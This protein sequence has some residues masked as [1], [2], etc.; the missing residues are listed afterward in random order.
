MVITALGGLG[1][2]TVILLPNRAI[3]TKPNFWP[4]AFWIVT[5]I[6][7]IPFVMTKILF[8]NNDIEPILVF[9]RDNQVDDMLTIGI[10]GFTKS[11]KTWALLILAIVASSFILTNYKKHFEK[12][13]VTFSIGMLAISPLTQYIRTTFLPTAEH[14]DFVIEDRMYAPE[15]LQK[16]SKQKNVV[17]VYLES[18][19]RSYG[20][21]AEFKPYFSPIQ[22]IADKSLELTNFVQTTGTGYTIAGVVSTQCGIPLLPNGLETVF[23]RNG[24]EASMKGFLPSVH[25][26]GDQLSKD[27]YTLYYMNGASLD[28]FSKRS[29][30]REHGYSRPFDI[31][32]LPDAEK[33]GRTNVW[34]LNDGLLFEN[35]TKEFDTLAASN[36][37][38]VQSI[39]SISTHGPDAFLDNDCAPNPNSTC[40]IPQ[41]IQCT[42]E[43]VTKLIKHIKESDVG[44]DT[45]VI[46]LNDHLA[47]FNS[48]ISYLDEV[49]ADRRNLFMI[50]GNGAPEKVSRQIAPFDIYLTI[51]ETLGYKIKD[52]RANMGVS[53]SSKN[54]NLVKELGVATVNRSFK[55]NQ[56]LAAYLWRDK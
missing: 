19:E 46:V 28:K 50:L 39:L 49:G 32:S 48:V 10:D 53:L 6:I 36:A 14:R 22:K 54:K 25:C 43:L 45:I 15:I 40:Q 34:G 55:G 12:I 47:F 16:P 3:D 29:F 41:A 17:I 33:Q 42:G 24:L 20:Q 1:Y 37:P 35:A 18:V 4:K 38:F 7:S 31:A 9:L 44:D 13:L 23:F 52:G 5:L 27:S 11:I 51:L 8:G 26:L 2:L 30:L 56:K 21:I